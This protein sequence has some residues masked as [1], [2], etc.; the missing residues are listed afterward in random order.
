MPI[1]DFVLQPF[2]P[3][4]NWTSFAVTVP[5]A[6]LPSMH[7]ILDAISEERL[8]EMQVSPQGWEAA[9]GRF[10]RWGSGLRPRGC[11]CARG[12]VAEH[13]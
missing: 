6:Q 2:E 5:E 10:W 7:E 13:A 8:A 9:R 11:D 12:S 3:E 1:T 4:L